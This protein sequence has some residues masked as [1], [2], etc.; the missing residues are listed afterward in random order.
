MDKKIIHTD[1]ELA[2]FIRDGHHFAFCEIYRRYWSVLY[3]HAY[4][5][6]RDEDLSMDIIQE[7]FTDLWQKREGLELKVSFKA[8]LYQSVRFQMLDTWRKNNQHEKFLSSMTNFFNEAENVTD[9]DV[10]LR[11]FVNRMEAEVAKLPPRM[12]EIFEQSRFEGKPNKQIAI[13]LDIS[14]HT[15]KKTLN[16][17]LHVLRTKLT[18]LF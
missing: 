12:R 14:D 17:V 11:E 6:S 10:N 4:K 16:R 2:A 15:V 9:A 18:M 3:L 13:E 7:I 1:D 8:Y 5:M